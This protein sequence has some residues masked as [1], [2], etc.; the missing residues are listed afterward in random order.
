MKLYEEGKVKLNDRLGEY[1]DETEGT[2][3]ENLK[4]RD[5]LTHRAGLKPWIPFYKETLAA[6]DN[7]KIMPS[8]EYYLDNAHGSYVIPVADN[9]YLTKKY[10]DSIYQAIL[11]SKLRKKGK[12]V[13][14]D[15]GMILMAKLIEEVDGR[16]LDVFVMEEFYR[17]MGLNRTRFNP[18]QTIS[19]ASIPPTEEDEYFRMQRIQGYVHDMGSAMLGGVSGHAGLFSNSQEIAALFQMLLNGGVYG[20]KRYLKASTI[21][22]FTQ[23]VKGSTRRGVGFDM[24]QLDERKT[25]NMSEKASALTFGHLGFTG[26]S[27][28]ADPKYNMVFIFLSNRTYPKMDNW[29]LSD[30]NYRPRLQSIPYRALM[31][32]PESS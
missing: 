6:G 10:R 1:L 15:L 5:I 9:L 32:N 19:P 18:L 26:I 29:L 27:A 20:G 23:R 31:Y 8:R 14:S 30:E 22:L 4:L 13:Y 12:Y 2:N 16:P 24:K 28:W 3:K 25:L 11:S 17:P 7:G 21:S